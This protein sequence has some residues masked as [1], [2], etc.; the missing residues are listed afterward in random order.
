MGL[1]VAEG[2]VMEMVGLGIGILSLYT[3]FIFFLWRNL[4]QKVDKQEFYRILDRF[5]SKE[6]V[7]ELTEIILRH[8]R[9][10]SSLHERIEKMEQ[11]LSEIRTKVDLLNGGKLIRE[12]EQLK[13]KLNELLRRME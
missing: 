3:T 9:L 12:V 6:R 1:Q 10:L 13:V 4:S 7:N 8:D 11:M 5:T 2:S